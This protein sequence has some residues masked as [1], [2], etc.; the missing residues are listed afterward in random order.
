MPFPPGKGQCVR[1]SYGPGYVLYAV[2]V[3]LVNP[4]G[5]VPGKGNMMPGVIRQGNRGKLDP[6]VSVAYHD[7]KLKPV[8]R[9]MLKNN[10]GTLTV[11]VYTP[12]KN[13]FLNIRRS[14]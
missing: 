13:C 9:F 10:R 2:N 7:V 1:K 6:R 8:I 4:A 14:G 12:G 11:P 5:S 3:S